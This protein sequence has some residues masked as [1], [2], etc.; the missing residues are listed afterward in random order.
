[1]RGIN[2]S[3]NIGIQLLNASSS[4][5]AGSAGPANLLEDSAQNNNNRKGGLL[6]NQIPGQT[7]SFN[8][9]HGNLQSY[10][11]PLQF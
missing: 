6:I 5:V 7:S 9:Q 10:Q 11:I 3:G 1:M 4:G 8:Q 2:T